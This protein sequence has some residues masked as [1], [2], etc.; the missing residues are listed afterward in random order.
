VGGVS[1]GV[2]GVVSCR[3]VPAGLSTLYL[4][5]WRRATLGGAWASI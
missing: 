2:G 3:A 4:V 1:G 5:G